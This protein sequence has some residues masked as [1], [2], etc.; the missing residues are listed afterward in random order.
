[1]FIGFPASGTQSL[2]L[3]VVMPRTYMDDCP[4]CK[5]I[6]LLA[7]ALPV[8]CIGFPVQTNPRYLRYNTVAVPELTADYLRTSDRFTPRARM[9]LNLALAG[10]LIAHEKAWAEFVDAPEPYGAF[11]EHAEAATNS[12][13]P[14]FIENL[15]IPRD[16]D[17]ILLSSTEYLLNKRAARI[18]KQ[19]AVQFHVKLF[20]YMNAFKVLKV[21]PI[22]NA[23]LGAS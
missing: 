12:N 5:T 9:E 23:P 18:L 6:P 4:F 3:F 19:S 8:W 22:K 11:Y 7:N 2:K 20:E 10:Q 13:L 14:A 1:M 21:V 17:V 16:W 15:D